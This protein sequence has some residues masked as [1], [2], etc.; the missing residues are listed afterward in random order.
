LEVLN[1]TEVCITLFLFFISLLFVFPTAHLTLLIGYV[2]GVEIGFILV[3]MVLALSIPSSYL[4]YKLIRDRF[5]HWLLNLLPQKIKQFKYKPTIIDIFF[6]RLN[7][8]IP[9][10]IGTYL[11]IISGVDLRTNLVNSLVAITPLNIMTLFAG[12]G[13]DFYLKVEKIG[14]VDL[15][16]IFFTLSIVCFTIS[17]CWRLIDAKK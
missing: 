8:M 17:L 11:L 12:A 6:L 3:S 16:T 5:G 10:P 1:Y 4:L 9:F 2:I 14:N 7:P 13:I 15:L